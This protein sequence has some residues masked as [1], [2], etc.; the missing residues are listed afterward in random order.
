MEFNVSETNVSLEDVLD[1]SVRSVSHVFFLED[2][3]L[4]FISDMSNLVSS[5][6]GQILIKS[7]D[8]SRAEHSDLFNMSMNKIEQIFD[9]WKE[10]FSLF[11][12]NSLLV[13]TD[14]F[15]EKRNIVSDSGHFVN[16]SID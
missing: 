10:S 13:L 11:E 7:H 6:D 9:I 3:I 16:G 12:R 4:D 5:A 2:F 1:S 8:E 15:S 14:L